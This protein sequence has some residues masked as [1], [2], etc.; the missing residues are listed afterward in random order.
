M[1]KSCWFVYQS[2]AFSLLVLKVSSFLTSW[3]FSL[4]FSLLQVFYF[5]QFCCGIHHPAFPNDQKKIIVLETEKKLTTNLVHC[6]GGIY[7]INFHLF[8]FFYNELLPSILFSSQ[9]AVYMEL[10]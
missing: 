2:W 8:T 3:P 4:L 6:H 7:V 10:S 1:V 5:A 9:M